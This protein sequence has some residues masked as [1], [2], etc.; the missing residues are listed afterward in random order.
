[1]K[2]RLDPLVDLRAD[3]LDQPFGYRVVVTGSQILMRAHGGAD[4]RL[5][6]TAH[7]RTVQ[8][9]PSRYK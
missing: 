8:P 9:V 7:V 3:P 2:L 5:V 1:V 4:L 6:V